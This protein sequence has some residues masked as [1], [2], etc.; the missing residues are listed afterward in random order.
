VILTTVS[1][2]RARRSFCRAWQ[3]F[4]LIPTGLAR[5]PFLKVEQDHLAAQLRQIK[6]AAIGRGQDESRRGL[7]G[8][9]I[10]T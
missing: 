9:W 7:T 8:A 5:D 3:I 1:M 2:P 4:H 10:P 6:G